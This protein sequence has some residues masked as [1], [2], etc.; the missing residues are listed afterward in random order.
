MVNTLLPAEAW[1]MLNKA[2]F[3]VVLC[4]NMFTI[5][6]D[7]SPAATALPSLTHCVHAVAD[8]YDPAGLG[9]N[10]TGEEPGTYR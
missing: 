6:C 10:Y 7:S 2:F 1:C 5:R 4:V 8:R 9:A 3:G